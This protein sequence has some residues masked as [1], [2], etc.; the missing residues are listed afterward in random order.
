MLGAEEGLVCE[1]QVD[2]IHLENV[3]E[4]QYLGCVLDESGTDE[5]K[6]SRKVVSVQ[7]MERANEKVSILLNGIWHSAVIDFGCVRSRIL[8]IKFKFSRV[9]V[10]VVVGYSP[11]EDSEER[12]RFWND[13]GSV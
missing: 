3:L 11:N 2:E 1:V 5:A 9:K 6:C 4:F 12:E 8:R 10:C 7:E 13:M